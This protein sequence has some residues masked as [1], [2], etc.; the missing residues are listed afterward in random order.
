M[1]LT[2]VG[3]SI[4]QPGIVVS[5]VVTATSF[6]GSVNASQLTGSLPAIDG[7]ALTGLTKTLTIGVRVGAAVTFN[8]TGS[9]FNVS[10]RSGNVSISV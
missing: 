6:V 10:A 2:K 3:G 8:V 9:S 7:S 5:G 1:A 4:L